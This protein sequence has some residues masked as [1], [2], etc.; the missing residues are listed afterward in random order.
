[1]ENYYYSWYDPETNRIIVNTPKPYTIDIEGR[2]DLDCDEKINE[3]CHKLNDGVLFLR[4]CMRA[5]SISN[6]KAEKMDLTLNYFTGEKLMDAGYNKR[7]KNKISTEF[8]KV[9]R[10]Y[11]W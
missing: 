11:D 1:M 8:L 6:K 4:D 2:V 9:I 7:K 5:L 3:T 10:D